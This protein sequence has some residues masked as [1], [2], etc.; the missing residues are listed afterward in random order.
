MTDLP[1]KTSLRATTKLACEIAKTHPDRFN[2]AVHANFYPCAPRTTPGKARSFAVDDIVALRLYQR[3]MDAGMS[4]S[5]AGAKVCAIREFMQVSPDAPRVFIIKTPLGDPDYLSEF[6]M[7][8]DF[9]MIND[10]QALEVISCEM[11][12]LNWHRARIVHYLTEADN[13]RVVGD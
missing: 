3:E 5:A 10:R 4:A 8:Q 11:I 12:D 6:D 7:R 2:E 1:T 9:T 13:N